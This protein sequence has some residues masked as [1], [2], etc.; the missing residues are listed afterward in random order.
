MENRVTC[1]TVSVDAKATFCGKRDGVGGEKVEF[2]WNPKLATC[3]TCLNEW[4]KRSETIIAYAIGKERD[5]KEFGFLAGP[6]DTLEEALEEI[7]E[8]YTF[9]VGLQANCQQVRLYR[10]FEPNSEWRLLKRGRELL[11]T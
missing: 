10:W 8:P 4:K 9:I 5:S 1:L 11:G 7:G 2:T 6:F 3:P